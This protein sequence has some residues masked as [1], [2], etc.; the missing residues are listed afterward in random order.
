MG[1]SIVEKDILQSWKDMDVLIRGNR[2]DGKPRDTCFPAVGDGLDYF[3]IA[4]IISADMVVGGFIAIEA[5]LDGGYPGH[6]QLECFLTIQQKAIAG[7]SGSQAQAMSMGQDGDKIASEQWFTTRNGKGGGSDAGH[8]GDEILHLGGAQFGIIVLLG[9]SA[10]PAI[11]I[12]SAGRIPKHVGG[13]KIKTC[14]EV[15]ELKLFEK[16]G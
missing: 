10:V 4:E 2:R 8:L 5:K 1:N 15:M 6:F 3:L 13:R 12:A 14:L 11:E 7:N 9:S 16:S